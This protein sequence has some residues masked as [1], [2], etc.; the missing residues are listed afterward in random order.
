MPQVGLPSSTLF[1]DDREQH[2]EKR[3]QARLGP[4]ADVNL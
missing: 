2:H 3:P 4:F 1:E